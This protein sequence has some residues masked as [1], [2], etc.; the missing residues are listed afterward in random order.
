[1]RRLRAPDGHVVREVTP[2]YFATLGLRIVQG[3]TFTAG[4]TRPDDR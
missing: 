2:E 4:I 1:M 3:R